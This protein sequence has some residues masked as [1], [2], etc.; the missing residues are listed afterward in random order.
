MQSDN[1]ETG[2]EHRTV[3]FLDTDPGLLAAAVR[4]QLAGARA[5]GLDCDQLL[6]DSGIDPTLLD[7]PD[8]RVGREQVAKLLRREWDLL[9]DESGGF[10][11]RPWIPGTFAMMGHACLSCPNLRRALLR[12]SRFVSMVSDDLQ[13]KLVED[14]EEARLLIHHGNLKQLPNQIFVE[15]LAVIWLRFFS[16]LI[17]RTILLER[18]HLAFPPPDYNEDYSD[19][20]PCRH[21]FHQRETC[22][23]FSTRYLQ[24]PLVRDEQ[25]LAEFLARAPECLLTQ[26]KSDNSYTGRVRRMLAGQNGIENLSLDDVAARLYTSPQTLRRRLKEEG[27]S[28]QDIKDSVRRDV[29]VYQLKKHETA[30]AEIAERLGFSEPSAFNRAFKKWTGLAPGAYRE[31]YRG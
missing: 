8:S 9:G 19:M 10:L 12:S 31:K 18:V 14:G 20:F 15:S 24:M 28:W 21:Y 23:V 25:Q 13:I 2:Q 16:W 22:L 29:A 26:Y 30:V 27:N 5:A 6:L 17:D 1:L 11:S 4:A 3:E 7:I